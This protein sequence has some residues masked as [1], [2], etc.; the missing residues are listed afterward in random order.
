MAVYD[1]LPTTNLK[2]DDVVDTL[3]AN[4]GVIGVDGNGMI[5]LSDLFTEGARINQWSARKPFA[6]AEAFTDTWKSGFVKVSEGSLTYLRYQLPKGGSAEPYR[7]GDFRGYKPG[8]E[9]PYLYPNKFGVNITDADDSSVSSKQVIVDIHN[10]KSLGKMISGDLG[11]SSFLFYNH[12]E[13]M[14]EMAFT[15]SDETVK[16]AN[17]PLTVDA[18][19]V[20]VA[21][22]CVMNINSYYGAF[23]DSNNPGVWCIFDWET[24][25][26]DVYS[27]LDY[28]TFSHPLTGNTIS[29][30]HIIFGQIDFL[31]NPAPIGGTGSI[32]MENYIYLTWFRL[33][34]EGRLIIYISG[35]LDILTIQ[36]LLIKGMF[37]EEMKKIGYFRLK[38]MYGHMGEG[39]EF[40]KEGDFSEIIN[41]EGGACEI[42]Y[43]DEYTGPDNFGFNQQGVF[44]K[45][46]YGNPLFIIKTPYVANELNS[47]DQVV[48][49]QIIPWN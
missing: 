29:Q 13:T 25:K 23:A 48:V 7:L 31:V 46:V 18:A 47:P 28:R 32:F 2:V 33:D 1:V 16:S 3:R 39:G 19:S 8:T 45:T 49:S 37:V 26:A 40:I 11:L 21:N 27:V 17:K 42:E 41:D 22:P 9:A 36:D 14:D 35:E 34:S 12:P 5:R 10:F 20:F 44:E 15:S 4:G 30:G 38:S 6:S 43:I 24:L